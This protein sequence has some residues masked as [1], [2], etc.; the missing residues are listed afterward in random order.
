M[1]DWND[2]QDWLAFQLL[3]GPRSAEQL[4]D[5]VIDNLQELLDEDI[6]KFCDGED[7]TYDPFEC[8]IEL[9]EQ[10]RECA[11]DAR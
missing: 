9:T 3:N 5:I 11:E 1:V 2:I 10:G 4:L 6:V 7:S 8:P